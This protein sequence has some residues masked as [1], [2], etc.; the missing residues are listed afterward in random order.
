M[1]VYSLNVSDL[2]E[3]CIS[4]H[5]EKMSSDRKAEIEKIKNPVSAKQ[6]IAAD[7]LRRI[8][9]SEFRCVQP[10][11]IIIKRTELGKPYTENIDVQFS[12]SHSGDMVVCAV[13]DI[14]IG[15]DAEKIRSVN[16][17]AATRFATEE[18]LD[19]IGENTERFFEIWTL[20]EAYFKC[21]GTGLGADIKNVS[22]KINSGSIECSDKGYKCSF[23]PLKDGYCCS[24][25]EK[26]SDVGF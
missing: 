8:A 10:N 13:S 25:C 9:I 24:I 11:D 1:K 3:E 23:Y 18:E 4:A 19:Y 14:E 26:I 17:R 20:K 12:V 21:I 7:Y 6:K 5:Y 22:F 2:T 16:F 15:I